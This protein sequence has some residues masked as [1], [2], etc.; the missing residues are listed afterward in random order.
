M[1]LAAKLIVGELTRRGFRADDIG[2]RI[3]FLAGADND[4]FET[5]CRHRASRRLWARLMRDHFG[6]TDERAMRYR[7]A[8]SGNPLNLTDRQ[9]L[10]NLARITMQGLAN[11]LGGCQSLVLPCWDEAFTIPTEEAVLLS[12]NTQRIIAYESGISNV[13][14][15]LAGSYFIESLTNE[16][17]HQIVA[18]M[19]EVDSRGGLIASIED[20]WIHRDMAQRA[21][22]QERAIQTGETVVVGVNRFQVDE[23]RSNYEQAMHEVNPRIAE[24]QR[25]RLE[26]VRHARNQTEVDEAL[27][28]IE[29]AVAAEENIMEP[30]VRATKAR[31]TIGEMTDALVRV[32]G[33]YSTA[34]PI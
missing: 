11:V 27:D 13:V 20:G 16:V 19:G 26:K 2:P 17:E 25:Q 14:D 33:R 15:P 18:W 28:A 6:V 34:L 5:V 3:T 21:Y 1:F 31:A 22:R 30:V 8:G 4:F 10:N 32:L 12:L 7:L 29:A 24:E 9:P 23:E